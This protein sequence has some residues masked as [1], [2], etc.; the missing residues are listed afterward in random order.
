MHEASDPF[1]RGPE[2]RVRDR[3]AVTEN[4]LK[5][6]LFN[7]TDFPCDRSPVM[8]QSIRPVSAMPV[9]AT[10]AIK[11]TIGNMVLREMK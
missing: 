3:S 8:L 11:P 6:F 1:L 4:S 7:P 9:P 5:P 2:W 10:A